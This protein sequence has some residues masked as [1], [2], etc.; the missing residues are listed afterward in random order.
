MIIYC[1]GGCLGNGSDKQDGYGSYRIEGTPTI[2]RHTFG[3]VT[4]NQAE[5]M[6]LRHVL[7]QLQKHRVK[8]EVTIRMDSQLA[9]KTVNGEWV[10]RNQKLVPLIGECQSLM[11]ALHVKLEWVP[12]ESIVAQVNH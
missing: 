3:N 11:L 5:Y 12:R 6:I 4:N 9:V 8:Q 2:Y 10:G 1:D 7:K